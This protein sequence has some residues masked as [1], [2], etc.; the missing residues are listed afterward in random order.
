MDGEGGLLLQCDF[1]ALD[2][3]YG[4]SYQV[5]KFNVVLGLDEAEGVDA[6]YSS[7]PDELE[8]ESCVA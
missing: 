2:S 5:L 4:D 8:T 3:G 7:L 6:R 1:V